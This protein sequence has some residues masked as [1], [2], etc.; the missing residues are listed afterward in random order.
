MAK[1]ITYVGLDVHK[2]TIAVTSAEAVARRCARARLD[3]K[4]AR[5]LEGAGRGCL[6]A[7]PAIARR[8]DQGPGSGYG[9]LATFGRFP[10]PARG[11]ILS[12][13]AYATKMG[14]SSLPAM[15]PVELG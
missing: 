7:D 8:A 6:I 15:R 12:L 10:R 3:P 1:S 4:Y 14:R 5:C 2:D 11:G 13:S 9:A